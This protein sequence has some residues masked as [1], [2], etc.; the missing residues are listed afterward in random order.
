M[1]TLSAEFSVNGDS[2]ASIA[3]EV[4][5]ASVVTL[6]L[7]SHS[8]SNQIAWSI[9]GVSHADMTAPT[10]SVS[11]SPSGATATFAMPAD[12]GDSEGRA[13]RIK[14][15]LRDSRGTQAVAYRV[16]G[17]PNIRGLIPGTAS[18][19]LARHPTLGWLPLF[20][21]VL[22]ISGAN[23]DVASD[24]TAASAG[25][26]AY[27]FPLPTSGKKYLLKFLIEAKEQVDLISYTHIAYVLAWHDGSACQIIGSP[28]IVI[29]TAH[30]AAG[31]SSAVEFSVAYT[32]STTN[33]V[34]T[35]TN[36]TNNTAD[37]NFYCTVEAVWGASP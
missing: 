28:S 14:C 19:E 29:N 34:A 15:I 32:E 9:D 5:Y 17:T 22:A 25:T 1:P 2:S 26:A 37:V 23:P 36:S 4:A 20:N 13:A 31:A 24:T 33:V 10:I 12:P 16:V 35:L 11:G 6:S 3:H 30:T 8:G 21:T 27:S 18:E 7:L